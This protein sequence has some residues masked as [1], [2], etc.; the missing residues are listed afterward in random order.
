MQRIH[1]DARLLN[2]GGEARFLDPSSALLCGLN[3]VQRIGVD[4]YI[5][6]QSS[7]REVDIAS[8]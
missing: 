2:G 8:T 7:D 3:I 6:R 1:G 5:P 4:Q